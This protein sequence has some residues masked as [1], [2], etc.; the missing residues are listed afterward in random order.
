MKHIKR[1]SRAQSSGA[2]GVVSILE[3]IFDFVLQ[4]INIKRG[5]E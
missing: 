3:V 2:E 5:S 4:V 1:L